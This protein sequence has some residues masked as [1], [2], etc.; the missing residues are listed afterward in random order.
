MSLRHN[1]IHVRLREL[2]RRTVRFFGGLS[3]RDSEYSFAYRYVVG[4]HVSVLDVG[5]SESLLP[6]Q[7][8]KRDYAVTV[9]DFREYPEQHPNITTIRGDFLSNALPDDSFD[10]VVMISTI[11]HIGLGGYGTPVCADGDFKAISEAKRV[12]KPGGKIVFTFPFVSKECIVT[13]FERWYDLK[14]VQ[15][16]FRGMYVLAEEYYVP[17][18]KIL[19]RIVKWLPA[20]LEQITTI[21]NV[22]EKYG[23]Q[24]NACY[25]VSPISRPN[26]S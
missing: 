18:T 19:G 5:G 14:R 21:E 11:E 13:G 15:R 17:H 1:K 4:E 6:F 12:L 26:F 25:V 22:V 10:Y 9:Y 20:S 2:E 7:F 8:A 24:C 23:Y 3:N 16:L